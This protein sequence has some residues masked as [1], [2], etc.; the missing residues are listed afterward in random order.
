MID[1]LPPAV[2]ELLALAQHEAL[3]YFKKGYRSSNRHPPLRYYVQVFDGPLL[4]NQRPDLTAA[5]AVSADC[6]LPANYRPA[7]TERDLGGYFAVGRGWI[8]PDRNGTNHRLMLNPGPTLFRRFILAPYS[9][10]PREV[11]ICSR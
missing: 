2:H 8:Y 10:A 6:I 3:A 11:A 9:G 5:F 4:W 1:S 7:G